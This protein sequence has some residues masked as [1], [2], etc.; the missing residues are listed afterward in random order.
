M[1]ALEEA[2]D[3]K[4]DFEPCDRFMGAR[5]G[6]EFKS[7]ELGLGYHRRG[8]GLGLPKVCKRIKPKRQSHKQRPPSPQ[9]EPSP[10]VAARDLSKERFKARMEARRRA[11]LPAAE[12]EALEREDAERAAAAAAAA[13]KQ[14]EEEKRE[15]VEERKP[16]GQDTQE[17]REKRRSPKNA[18]K[19]QKAEQGTM[20]TDCLALESCRAL[21]GAPNVECMVKCKWMKDVS[22][23]WTEDN[24]QHIPCSTVQAFLRGETIEGPNGVDYRYDKQRGITE[25]VVCIALLFERLLLCL[26]T[27]II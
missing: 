23:G 13:L 14:Q 9:R 6:F 25:E 7:S 21:G 1:A 20:C 8:T 15:E 3:T 27:S 4:A 24:T 2:D 11:K 19:S 18:K 17:R 22:K 5:D 16:Q 26:Y 12:R 10:H